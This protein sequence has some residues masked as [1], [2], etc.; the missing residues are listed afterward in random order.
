MSRST[1]VVGRWAS[2]PVGG[3]P[4]HLGTLSRGHL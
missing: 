4:G 3:R 2:G 1:E